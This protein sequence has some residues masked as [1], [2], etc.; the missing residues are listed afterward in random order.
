MHKCWVWDL[1]SNSV[2]LTVPF[3]IPWAVSSCGHSCYSRIPSQGDDYLHFLSTHCVV[4]TLVGFALRSPGL[5]QLGGSTN[6]EQ[7]K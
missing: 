4:G 7:T 2:W 3:P 6:R 1:C 5:V